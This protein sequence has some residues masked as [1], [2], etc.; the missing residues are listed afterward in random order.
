LGW[1][2]RWHGE[3]ETPGGVG[4]KSQTP[5]AA[6]AGGT[7]NGKRAVQHALGS[8][9]FPSLRPALRSSNPTPPQ[10]SPSLYAFASPSF[11]QNPL[12]LPPPFPPTN[13]H[14][15]RLNDARP[16]RLRAACFHP[17]DDPRRITAGPGSRPDLESAA[18]SRPQVTTGSGGP[19][20]LS[21][22]LFFPC[23]GPGVLRSCDA[24]PPS[25][26]PSL[27]V[28]RGMILASFCA[29][30]SNFTTTTAVP[31]FLFSLSLYLSISRLFN[32]WMDGIVLGSLPVRVFRKSLLVPRV[33]VHLAHRVVCFF[34]R[35][36]TTPSC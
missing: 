5:R 4:V 30:V 29:R 33:C 6:G 7:G 32:F 21:L 35:S 9:S 14:G 23:A 25:L 22:S 27:R 2:R 26:P 36:P 34:S 28:W 10:G 20:F 1:H 16:S 8:L 13:G 19:P 15:R 12:L 17:D 31:P 11:P 18:A 24:L 3:I